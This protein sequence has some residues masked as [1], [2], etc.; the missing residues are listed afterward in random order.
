[1][2]N[3]IIVSLLLILLVAISASA[4]SAS[5]D[6]TDAITETSDSSLNL[7]LSEE[8]TNTAPISEDLDEETAVNDANTDT[9]KLGDLNIG[10]NPVSVNTTKGF[11]EYVGT[12]KTYGEEATFNLDNSVIFNLTSPQDIKVSCTIQ[13][14]T[15]KAENLNCFFNVESPANGGPSSVTIK[16]SK[17]I[18]TNE[19]QNVIFANGKTEG[20]NNVINIAGITLENITLEIAD[21]VSTDSISLLYLNVTPTNNLISNEITIT[22]NE[23]NGAHSIN[24]GNIIK[25]ANPFELSEII[26]EKNTQIVENTNYIQYAVDTA[27]G[28][29]AFAFTVRL[30]DQYGNA[31]VNKTVSFALD[32]AD[33]MTAIT[34]SN[35]VARLMLSLSKARKYSI[36]T[37]FEGDETG[38]YKPSSMVANNITIL[39]KD[40]SLTVKN[41][42]YKVTATKKLSVTFKSPV[43]EI[44]VK[45]INNTFIIS[46]EIK[47]YKLI[48][49]KK[50]TFTVNGK[51]YAATTNSKGVATVK[52]TL[53]KKGT[54]KYTAKFEG[55][56]LYN[57]VTKKAK[58]TIKPLTTSL[59]TKKYK[60]R[61]YAKTKKLTTTLKSGK[62]VLKKQ[63]VTFKVNGKTYT[64]KTN[65]KGI[66]TVKIKLFKKGTYKYTVKYAGTNKYKAISKANKVIIVK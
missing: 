9:E 6:S 53:N 24:I 48:K 14:G 55:D 42:S 38:E 1:M 5:E 49:N 4:V 23:L 63:K 20:I 3:K 16:N 30:I 34:D 11:I 46:P 40:S 59:T 37:F 26:Y 39:K 7:E 47:S 12:G 50:V 32:G 15:L 28:D 25:D 10:G 45:I 54:Y 64:A 52:I 36:I 60:F 21:G 8:D 27:A 33:K 2:K 62:T 44:K 29:P 57:A 41:L 66:A 56:S 51:T 13:G 17:F 18:I 43:Y 22:G 61:R 31:V 58:L 19:N 35:G 65:S